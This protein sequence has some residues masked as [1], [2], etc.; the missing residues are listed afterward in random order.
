MKMSREWINNFTL[1]ELQEKM[2]RDGKPKF[3]A[4]QIFTGLHQRVVQN[5]DEIPVLGKSLVA[6]LREFYDIGH[7]KLKDSLH[8]K[9]G[10]TSKY[11]FQTYDGELLETVLMKYKHG[12]SVCVSTQIGCAMRCSFCASGQFG[13]VRNLEAFEML[14]QIYQIQKEQQ[15]KVGSIVLMGM[16]EPLDNYDEV[17]RFMRLINHPAGQNLGMRHITLSTCG[18]VPKI[19]Q[20]AEENLQITLSISLH[21]IEDEKRRAIMPIAKRYNLDSLLDACKYYIEKTNRRITF[22]YTLIEDVNDSL[23]DAQ[24]LVERLSNLLCHVNLIPLNATDK[25]SYQTTKEKQVQKFKQHLEKRGIQVTVRREMGTDI[26]AACGQLRKK[27]LE[28]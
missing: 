14:E 17:L 8:S 10:H 1:E 6:E 15:I 13:K 9:D 21:A 19:M 24:K 4:E 23:D 20:L 3:R 11:L 16:G 28:K 12:Y 18:I 2:A 26:Q 7:L 22:E 25:S 27:Y 5:F